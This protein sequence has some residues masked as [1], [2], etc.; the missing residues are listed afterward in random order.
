MAEFKLGRIKFVY[1][2]NWQASTSYVVDDVI[3][4]GGK[5]YICVIAH[6]SSALFAT[7]VAGGLGVTKWNLM[8]DGQAWR[9]SWANAALY[10]PGD[11]I[12]YGS[13]IYQC[14]IAHTSVASTLSIT[15]TG[16][17]VTGGT[18]TLNFAA[19]TSGIPF[20]V[21]QTITL[22]GFSPANT[23]GTVNS[24]N[25]SFTVLTCS[26]TQITF[27][28]TGTYTLA[29]PGTVSGTGYLES[30]IN[31]WT[32]FATNLNWSNAWAV[33]TKY[34]VNDLIY[35]GGV[36]YVCN[37]P[38]ISSSSTTLGL[39]TN[40][41]LWSTFNAG[42]NYL[43]PWATTTRYKLN[44]IV[45]Y[46]ADLWICT[47]QHTS[48]GVTIN[49]TNFT[50]FVNGL[51]FLNSWSNTTN[52]AIGD[53]V[54]Y[55]GYTYTAILNHIA[56]IPSTATAYWQLFTTG[57]VY[58]GAWATGNAYKIGSVVTLGGFTYVAAADNTGSQP[59]VGNA[60]WN[61]LNSGIRWAQPSTFVYSNIA[62]NNVVGTGTSAT[63]DITLNGTTY[64][65]AVHA[66]SGGGG[67]VVG[68]TIKILG[69]QLGG[70]SPANDLLLTV[71]TVS[72]GAI[73]TV[74]VT[75]GFAVTWRTGSTY[76]VGDA[77]YY[78]NSSYI[79]VS[80][81]VSIL[82]TNDPT[83]DTT[84]SYWNLLAQGA[85]GGVLTTTGDMVY[86]GA[87]GATRL[88]VGT[89]GQILRVNG[90]IPSWQYYGLLQNIVY[91]APNGTDVVGNSQGQSL[92]KPWAT[93]LFA[94]K[95]IEE[96]YLNTSAGLALKI[97]KQFMLKEVNNFILTKY[98]FNITGSSPTGNTLIVGG[99]STTTQ[100]TTAN[101][102]Y[103]MPII[104]TTAI[105]SQITPGV[106]YYVNTI[107]STTTFTISSSY[108]NGSTL[109]LTGSSATTGVANF[110]YDSMKTERDVG[111]LVDAVVFDLTHGGNLY[112]TTACQT[113]FATLTSLITTNATQEI[114]VWIAS[115]NYL[116]NVLFSSVLKNSPPVLNYQ[117]VQGIT[118]GGQALQN[119]SEV[120]TT[121]IESGS[122]TTSQ[123]LLTL[124]INALGAGTYA[125]IPQLQR[126]HTSIYLKTGTYN[127]YG[128]IVIPQ[129]T[130]I[131]GDELRSTIVQVASAQP[132]LG[133]DN[134]RTISALRRIQNL[135]PAIASNLPI[136]PTATNSAKQLYI[137][138]APYG[139]YTAN[140]NSNATIIQTIL[141][142]GLAAVPGAGTTT[143]TITGTGAGTYT[144]PNTGT[145]TLTTPTGFG[146]TLSN[147]SYA[148]S[149]NTPGATT[150]YDGGVAQLTQNI[151]FIQTEIAAYM[152]ANY[153]SV[154]SAMD[155]TNK[156]YTLRDVGYLINS[157]IYDMTYGG[158][159]QSQIDGLAYWTLGSNTI[160]SGYQAATN[161][162]MTRLQAIIQYIV[163]ANTGSWTTTTGN[164]ASQVVSG[165]A[166]STAAGT[167]ATG[168]V[169]TVLNWVNG[170]NG[171]GNS[172]SSG[173]SLNS[174]IPPA[175]SWVSSANITAFTNVQNNR[176]GIQT[177]IRNWVANNY[178]AISAT[179]TYRDAGTIADA[180][181]YD[182]LLGSTYYS[183]VAGRAFYR[184][185]TSAQNLVGNVNNELTVTTQAINYIAAQVSGY[186]NSSTTPV[187]ATG[188]LSLGNQ[189][190]VPSIV[191]NSALL[192]NILANGL[193][194]STFGTGI[195]PQT[196][197]A[198][199]VN[200]S[201]TGIAYTTTTVALPAGTPITITRTV[202]GVAI[203]GNLTIGGTAI[204]TIAANPASQI[205]Y[206]GTT[207]TATV[208]TLYATYANAI[209]GTSPLTVGGTTTTG[210]TFTI[211]VTTPNAGTFTNTLPTGFG[212]SLTNTAYS[213]TGL[214]I[215]GYTGN[216][217][218]ATTGY[219]Y[220]VAN[221]SA[222]LAFLQTEIANYLSAYTGSS[223][224]WNALTAVQ[225]GQAIRDIG[226]L[227]ES[228]QYDMTYGGNS[229][230]QVDGLGYY[231]LTTAYLTS[232]TYGG[233]AAILAA[234]TAA[235]TRLQTVIPFIVNG[236]TAGWTKTTGNTQTQ[237]TVTTGT[238]TNAG[239]YAQALIGNVL[240][241]IAGTNG[242]GGSASTGIGLGGTVLPYYGWAGIHHQ[243]AF[244]TIQA[245]RS[246]IQ[247]Q[248]QTFVATQYPNNVTNL[249]LTYRDAG[250]IVDALSYDMILGSNYFTMVSGRAFYRFSTSAQNLVSSTQLAATQAATQ[251][252][253]YYVGALATQNLTLPQYTGDF[254][255]PAAVNLV[256]NNTA[257]IQNMFAN[258][259]T[260]IP[261]TQNNT[262]YGSAIGLL[263]GPAFSLPQVANY[264]TYYLV[265][266]GNGVTQLQN[267]YQFIKDEI[268]A[269]LISTIGGST[270]ANY[271]PTYQAET[272]RDLSSVLD[273]LQYDLTYGCNNQ[274]LIVGSSYYSLNT[275]L[276][277]T[278]YTTGVLA[279]LN[280]LSAIISSI[281]TATGISA[282][283]G[284]STSQSTSG[285]AGSASAGA[286]AVA[287]VQDIIYW[288][289][290]G[291]PN[292]TTG[293]GTATFS[294]STMT[295]SAVASGTFAV[296]QAVTGTTLNT[297]ATAVNGSTG[298]VTLTSVTGLASGMPITF[299]ATTYGTQAVFSGLKTTTYT[300]NVVS[301]STVTLY[302]YGTSTAPTLTT[303]TGLLTAISGVAPGTYITSI[304]STGGATGAYTVSVSQTLAAA[305][306]VTGT[307]AITPLV[308]GSYNFATPLNQVSFN[309]IQTQATL[310]AN[311]AQGWVTRFF[312][313]E[314]P[315]LSLTNRD[316]GY[317]V[318]ALSYDVLFNSNFYTIITGRSYNRLIPS[319]KSL[320]SNYAD[321]TYGVIGF[322]GQ[323]VKVIAAAGS[324]VQ[325][326]TTIDDMI[327]QIYGQP[328][329][330][331]TF[332][333]V[334]NGTQLTVSRITSGAIVAGMP[335]NGIGVATGTSTVA[336]ATISVTTPAITSVTGVFSCATLT[337]PLV[338]GQQVTI[339][340]TFSAGS[341]SGYTS[342]T[343]YYVIGTPTTTAFQLSATQGGTAVT[344]TTSGGTITGI[345]VVASPTTWLLNY[346]QSVSST[347]TSIQNVVPTT[348]Y[349]TMG[350]TNG[351]VPGLTITITGT[352]ISNLTA[353]T[354]Y[355]KQVLNTTQLTL[356]ATYNGPVFSVTAINTLSSVTITS[357]AGTFTCNAVGVTLAVG[358]PVTISGTNSGS[359]A[360]YGYSTPSVYY[361]IATNG[362][363][364]FT[365]SASIGG[366]AIV[367]TGG[368]PSGWTYVVGAQGSMVATVYGIYGGLALTTDLVG[369]STN[370]PVTAVT[371]STNAITVSSNAGVYINMPVV[372]SGLPNNI[373]T[374]AISTTTS[375]NVITLAATTASLGIVAG[376][377]VYFTGM[378]LGQVV[379]NQN[380]YVINP[381]GSTIQISNTLG[382]S[383]VALTTSPSLS[384]VAITGTGG[385]FSCASYSTLYV[386]QA[387]TINGTLSAGS[388]N[389]NTTIA[390]QTFY[391]IT[392]NG[393]TTFTLSAT[394]GGTAITTTA[395]GG[396]IT[397][398]TFGVNAQMS[399]VINAAG[400]LVNGDTYYVNTV[401]TGTYPAAGNSITVSTSYKSG[402][403][404][405]ITNS[406]T[407]LTAT[408]TIGLYTS[409]GIAN[410]IVNGMSQP[411]G[412]TTGAYQSYP[413]YNNVLSTITGSELLR[414]NKSF[415]ASEATFYAQTTFGTTVTNTNANGTITTST[416]HNL[417]VNDPVQ[418]GLN[419][420]SFDV[421]LA[422]GTVYWVISTPTLTTFT[423]ST[424]QPGTGPQTTLV[425]GGLSGTMAVNYYILTD[426][427]QRDA[428][429][430]IDGMVYDLALTGNYK[431]TRSAQVYLTAVS[432]AQYTNLFLLRN[433]TGIRNM[434][435]NG[436]LGAL[437]LPNSLGTKRPTG[438]IYTGLDAGFGPNDSS[439]WIFN[440]SP[441][442]QNLTNFGN[443]C[444]GMKIDAALHNGG[445]KSIVSNDFTQVLSDGIGI[446]CT[447][448]GALTECVSVF[449]Y[450]GYAGYFAEYGGRIRATNGNSSYGYYGA[451]AE[452]TD[453]YETPGYSTINNRGNPAYITNVITDATNYI[454]RL[455][456]QNAG[457]NYTN[458]VPTISGAGYNAVA[459]GDEF[460]D[461]A[462]F[463][464]RL[465]DLNN[466]QGVGG[467][468]YLTISNTAQSGAVGSITI[469]NSDT[470][471]STAYIGMR[472]F[473]TGG[474]GVG[475]YGTALNYTSGSK[476]INVYRQNFAQLTIT[477]NTTSVFTVASTNTMYAS[478]PI[479][480]G[481]AIG[482]LSFATVYYVVGASLSNNGTTFSVATS[483]ANAAAGTVQTLT[484]TSATPAV[485]NSST[486][487]GTTLTVGTLASGTIY[488]G[489]L[490]TGTG[491]LANTYIVSNI[492]GSGSGSTWTVTI[493]QNLS[494]TN[495]TG[496]IS[497][498][499][500]EA[501]WDHSV[502][503]YTT[504]N[505]LDATTTYQIEPMINYS[506]PGFTA[507]G[508]TIPAA[509]YASVTY[510]NGNFVATTS[511]GAVTAYSTNGITW[512][513][514]GKLP[515]STTWNHVRYGGGEGVV[516]TAVIGGLGGSGCVL[517][518]VIG[519]GSTFG[520][521]IGINIIT[522]GN[523]YSTPP[524]IVISD[525]TGGGA[526][527]IAQVLGGVV[528]NVYMSI[529]GSL[530]SS[531]PTVTAITSELSSI[532][533]SNWGNNYYSSPTVIISPPYSA[534]QWVASTAAVSGNYYYY[535]DTTVSPN[536]TNYYLAGAT[537][538]FSS[539]SPTFTN[540]YYGKSGASAT[541]VGVSGTYG[542]ALTY[543]G[544]LPLVTANLTTNG[545]SSY[546][547]TQ[548]G[549][550]YITT[551]TVTVVDPYAAYVAIST[552]TN[553][554][555]YNSGV[556]T[557]SIQ[558]VVASSATTVITL[559]YAVSL[560]QN[561]PITFA[562]TF[563][564]GPG[565]TA[566]TTYYVAATTTSS[567]SLT[568]ASSIN[569]SAITIGTTT[570]LSII[571]TTTAST[572]LTA[573]WLSGTSTGQTTLK[574]LAYG[575][576]YFVAVGGSG[577]A[578]AVSL[579]N[580]S[581]LASASWVNQSGN[582]TTNSSGYTAIAYG[583]GLFCAIG[584]TVS[585]FM[586]SNP[587]VWA[588]GGALTSKT[589]AGL[590]YGNGRFVA[591]ATDGTLQYSQNW[592]PSLWTGTTATNNTWV[593]V[594]NNPLKTS[595]VI[596]WNNIKYGQGMFVAISSAPNDTFTATSVSGNII[597]VS[598]TTGLVVGAAIIPTA[599]IQ[600][601]T[602]SITTHS[603]SS[604]LG[605]IGNGAASPGSGNIFTPLSSTTGTWAVGALLTSS[606]T[607]TAGTYITASN[608]FTSTSS[609]ISGTTLTVGGTITGAVS[610][611]QQ[612]TGPT[613]SNTGAYI[614]NS[615][616][617][618]ASATNVMV[619]PAASQTGT[620]FVG[621]LLS[622]TGISANTTYVTAQTISTG[623]ISIAIGSTANITA[624]I[625][626]TSM[627]VTANSG[628]INIGMVLG[629]GT[630]AA[631]TFIVAN[632]AGTTTSA[633][634]V[635]T[636]S[637]SQTATASTA[638][639]Y[640]ATIT[641]PVGSF[642]P[643]MILSG[644]TTTTGT[645]ITAQISSTGGA[646]GTQ[647]F[648]SGGTAGTTSVTLAAGT[649]FV[650]G[651]LI[652]GT[653]LFANTYITSVA[654]AVITVSQPFHTNA[655][656]SYTSFTSTVAG[657]YYVTPAQTGTTATTGTGYTVTSGTGFIAPTTISGQLNSYIV[658]FVGGSGAAGTYTINNSVTI[659]AGTAVNG[660]SYT[661]SASQLTTSA[662]V[663][664]TLDAIT[665]GDTTGMAIGEPVVFTGSTGGGITSGTTYYVTEV[666]SGTLLSIGA[667]YLATTNVVLNGGTPPSAVSAGSLLGGLTSGATYY[668]A[669]IGANQIT[670]SSSPSLTPV[671]TLTGAVG[672]W[673]AVAGEV[674]GIYNYCATSWDGLNWTV[675][676]M[677]ALS[678]YQGLAFGN[679]KNATL[680]SVPTWVSVS[681]TNATNAA[682]LQTGPR[683]LGRVKIVSN[684][685]NEIRMIEP[686]S[687][688]PR[689]NVT[690][691][692][693]ST[694]VVTVDST[695][696]LIANMPVVFN[697]TSTGNIT[698]GQYYYIVGGSVTSIT[699]QISLTAGSSAIPLTSAT[700]TGMTY[701]AG[702]VITIT[703][704]NHVNNVAVVPRIGNN[705][706]GNP[707][708]TN[709]GV[710]NTT[711]TAIVAGDGYSDL[712]QIG[713]YINVSGLY[714]IPSPGSNVTFATIGG[715]AQWY[716]LVAVTNQLGVPG[717]YTATFQV[718][719]AMSVL[720]A[721]PHAT[722]M[723]TRLLYSN[724]R[725]T[726]HDFLY[727]GT[728]GVTATNY[729]N[730]DPSKAVQA[731]QTY[732]TG[733]GRVFF[734]ST[735]QDGNF[736]VGNLFGVQQSTGTATLNA[737]AFNLSGLQSL[738]LG[739]VNLGVGSATITQFST[740]PYFTANSDN[741]VPTQ[742]AIKAYITSQIGGGQ[743]ALNVNT[744]TSGQI[745]IAGNTITTTTGNQ[746][747]VS[748]KM[749]FTGG[750]DGSPVA[751]A[752][753]SQR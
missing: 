292:A 753:F 116:N 655:V 336:G 281:I 176:T 197:L 210:A 212:S 179:L 330:N 208:A 108:K 468:N 45:K 416:P 413:G 513:A 234:T 145:Y 519:T 501:G 442:T 69:T 277:V 645:V 464:S 227:L 384:T 380:Y 751:L 25:A 647:N 685:V 585:S 508:T 290:N 368:T 584:G 719:P 335:I 164:N 505:V 250:T 244:A 734:T 669:S 450:Y 76:L 426:R 412:N 169:T 704:P 370:I 666:I 313:N 703:D 238:Y 168:L 9:G 631:G 122:L 334:V 654:G 580:S 304:G 125:G 373:T 329:T 64:A 294:G 732:A 100:T 144:V 626:G 181:S 391:I 431:S 47:T 35:Y 657:G 419:G 92:D 421:T 646:G 81:H 13:T 614:L 423:V 135:L 188:V 183:M 111:T 454:L 690:S 393:T 15:A 392:T 691:T 352:A 374:T 83:S 43:G 85:N 354:Y 200:N 555:A 670:V 340:G 182:L 447:G 506:A 593:T 660:A 44:D 651:Q 267:N 241:W 569:G 472:V 630:V 574:S 95:Q 449:C 173:A 616:Y 328:S 186:A 671:V 293:T 48:S 523:N 174:T 545:V 79:C 37:T 128:P 353:G 377:R 129:D 230:T 289:N 288:L 550:G 741:I 679:P 51:E 547:I 34:K 497:V 215:A 32:V 23:S 503:G 432:G 86:Y 30:Q 566:G 141:A 295:V 82:S 46:G 577:S 320:Q 102:Y 305:T 75:T 2:G 727:I 53:V 251:Y 638:T 308:S 254:G 567:T 5:T 192:Q 101:M 615:Y 180:L 113:Y 730:V 309:A 589:W 538:T 549:F 662:T 604:S 599:V 93:L 643:G 237:V 533:V 644:G 379:F 89:D 504:A 564:A 91:V 87:N 158:N 356:S 462:V 720:L 163:T 1:Q 233:T 71:A 632:S 223:F 376:Q 710:G 438:G 357:S 243:N 406:L 7:D 700:I 189:I 175:T 560:A 606:G 444:V 461:S 493:T 556:P 705:A 583:A 597:T 151:N 681:N 649:S 54:T 509:Q 311:D 702:P 364:S 38:H 159:T 676:T 600:P 228:I 475:Q 663:T 487:V 667:S 394:L 731:N 482:G 721:P 224:S 194:Y 136:I 713:N 735:D 575:N 745:Y 338:V 517:Q 209:A 677:P 463:E 20:V 282:T 594:N 142:G 526:I 558:V 350:T 627:T 652:T 596:T 563:G 408:A 402:T 365:L 510:G 28:L 201:T 355:I 193:T 245:Q 621:G 203:G 88:P 742:K 58:S 198:S 240:N 590:A 317:V 65:A 607:I 97:N 130:A 684:I 559:A 562:T 152:A 637:I 300:I 109:P 33:S 546:T 369:T 489:M 617:T 10:N 397:G 296:G 512:A 601:T 150:G 299:S 27:A 90:A 41:S 737:S 172:L 256:V 473:L 206:T 411:W 496:T 701:F 588:A 448:H 235:I 367:T 236:A 733:G 409:Q 184:L 349:I 298:A 155:A 211:G 414:L 259:L 502:P 326:Q 653:G 271:G 417:L 275:P 114:T 387:I 104:F 729:P 668:V 217:T 395:S 321:S 467:S 118:L 344:S 372:F 708:F 744:I 167:Y 358:Q 610:V 428:G 14:T 3:T 156:G 318:T 165:A 26:T 536:V 446:W 257:I 456:Y 403:V 31:N 500:Y 171:T 439:A 337:T 678:A 427:A 191:N 595:G 319:V 8:S 642:F 226:Y 498:Q 24:V 70:L 124:I 316:A 628:T 477:T 73:A 455:E 479:Y 624:T 219:D 476:I 279:A 459:L 382:G 424:T 709:R 695:T 471:L 378:M 540:K 407:G 255:N 430:H 61:Q 105:T 561:T 283:S 570:G 433:G 682:L 752:F 612:I 581:S 633:V 162:M 52:Y 72:S 17:A 359:G 673:S 286:F 688:F 658:A 138:S 50:M 315:S 177:W 185:T 620:T 529:T 246:Y 640:T 716:K 516:S 312:Q 343:I 611:G 270:W 622:G 453:S 67:Y 740:D 247:T 274:S 276:I 272:I 360:I 661:V 63:F 591:L 40:Q 202:T 307:F 207:T 420:T 696:N 434:T 388:I 196:A 568:L 273:A 59:A 166:G 345:T 178:P 483:A 507:T 541:G 465:V 440:R 429:Y 410:K 12:Q 582:I 42:L 284:N 587:T 115:L 592:Q 263:Q 534:T 458:Y 303:G 221:I 249:T 542:V 327:A 342:G 739:S 80:S 551:P 565:V 265:G 84:A 722:Q 470:N 187:G 258:A 220:G 650:A 576:N 19:Q 608:T 143:V 49:T 520:Q 39:E 435:L 252:I 518:A 714:S 725:M 261:G 675:L 613:F 674:G 195:I 153:F 480:L 437:T 18:A 4:N 310:I 469:A 743:S 232:G 106:I 119:F 381:T 323:K 443:G 436:M 522:G 216:V 689:G 736:N 96:G 112:V 698:T 554:V 706:L 641:S 140:V 535:V 123:S 253:G 218:G 62:G 29:T 341:I 68:N 499:V 683:P 126:P 383:A 572:N 609:T 418:F 680:G 332:T 139:T 361:I 242:T 548:A 648:A 390:A 190:T 21:G 400:G 425:L 366:Q 362:S 285:S 77:V 60:N 99:S 107:T 636:V 22:A 134:T 484:A 347:V 629:G 694:N 528:T 78:S 231:T 297:T 537:G 586:Q 6:T 712:Y 269:Y 306:T 515:S 386:G 492:S 672:T 301:G 110:S 98:S 278:P 711:A 291:I 527:A 625:S 422:A 199:V 346:S 287:R 543:V 539:T 718:N 375:T 460:R 137:G 11:L 117:T 723:T 693:S 404:F 445:T 749:L 399:V 146:T 474:T 511:T 264:N 205:Y 603:V 738:T 578:S 170:N 333:G 348:N 148:C 120:A 530:Y 363:T 268:V 239:L 531:T 371:T 532:T 457:G 639:P 699:F 635:W 605:I 204:S 339:T 222:N 750:I 36:T 665:V 466:N 488:A 481:A 495:I 491:V 132:Y 687:G 103:G 686:G 262:N 748:S 229:Q 324:V 396:T 707:S 225:Q 485:M 715:S 524:T 573:A 260:I 74:T 385:Q 157:I 697:G 325:T 56:Q 623:T 544:S 553:G 248:I 619:M 717:N 331:C 552:S 16:L 314:G 149:G 160:I 598:N 133:N 656:G 452:G 66:G 121:S 94:C 692:T 724:T 401:A 659:S 557:A 728:G 486:I 478:Q 127:E 726:G 161:G 131:L 389:S 525:S 494:T 514:G 302:N 451:I 280:R 398:T 147:I 634:S 322:I 351:M 441:Y 266:Y 213:V 747:Y 415:L 746:I 571:G 490:L 405:A 57:L 618:S 602:A 214:G 521:V 55:G 579:Y 154:W 664:G